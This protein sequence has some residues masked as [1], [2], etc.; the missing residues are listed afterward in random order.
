MQKNKVSM[1]K[2]KVG[3]EKNVCIPRTLVPTI[4]LAS[5]TIPLRYAKKMSYAKKYCDAIYQ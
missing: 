3:M 4:L 2:N 5:Q 1:Q